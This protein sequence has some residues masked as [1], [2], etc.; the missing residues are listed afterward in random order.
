MAFLPHALQM[1]LVRGESGQDS[2]S[3]SDALCAVGGTTHAEGATKASTTTTIIDK[4][5][6]NN[7]NSGKSTLLSA[8]PKPQNV[9]P[10]PSS[11]SSSS[12]GSKWVLPTASS[13]WSTSTTVV[14]RGQAAA[15]HAPHSAG[16]SP[17]E[18]EP[19]MQVDVRL[20][21]GKEEG[22]GEEGEE[23]LFGLAAPSSTAGS[24]SSA[25]HYS[26]VQPPPALSASAS[27]SASASSS[28]AGQVEAEAEAGREGPLAL[29]GAPTQPTR[30]LSS[31][32]ST[33]NSRKRQRQLEAQL[34]SGN[35]D[36]LQHMGTTVV[37][38]QAPTEWD[39]RQYAQRKADEGQV[40]RKYNASAAQLSS[41]AAGVTQT[42]KRK[43]QITS[44]AVSAV[45]VRL[46]QADGGVAAAA[47]Q[48]AK[49]DTKKQYGW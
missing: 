32:R 44:L 14:R 11:S 42:H 16:L 12:S 6:S 4:S 47:S 48:A 24:G 43:N 37:E 34:Q 39:S 5:S 38:A 18:S 19:G 1:A 23:D 7:S 30:S 46:K 33:S 10:V 41:M 25:H 28:V 15:V 31:G 29:L 27:A 26:S 45:E 21:G 35:M 49:E 17:A 36:V 3:D 2:D 22:E 8:L 9:T 40:R 13:S 20:E